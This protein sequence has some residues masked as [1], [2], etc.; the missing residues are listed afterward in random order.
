MDCRSLRSLNLWDLLDQP[1]R[2]L[3]TRYG[4]SN[5]SLRPPRPQVFGLGPPSRDWPAPR[6]STLTMSRDQSWLNFR[7]E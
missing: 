5:L 4:K 6:A 2:A 1:W 7:D 3:S